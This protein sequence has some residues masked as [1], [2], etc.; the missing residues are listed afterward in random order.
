MHLLTLLLLLVGFQGA[1]AA[2][3]GP[4]AQTE[5]VELTLLAERPEFAPDRPLWLAFRFELAPGWHVYWRNPG[6]SGE[7]PRVSWTLPDGWKVGELHWPVPERIPVGPLVNY[8]YKGAVMLLA[9]AHP[10]DGVTG[11]A[12]LQADVD[13]LVCRESCIPQK[14]RLILRL[15]A[16]ST[17]ALTD[18]D[19]RFEATRARWPVALPGQAGYRT[20]GDL[21]QLAVRQTGWTPPPGTSVWFAADR[22]GP[23]A[24][25][26]PQRWHM[27]DGDL[28]V[29]LPA[30][31]APPTADDRLGGVLVVSEQHRGQTLTRGF[32]VDAG[33]TAGPP[34]PAADLPASTH[35]VLVL[36]LAFAGGLL[37]N[38]MPCVLPVLSIKAMSLLTHGGGHAARHGLAY[39]GGVL[40]CFTALAG[41]LLMLRAGGSALGWGFQLQEPLIVVALMYLML[42][43]AL[44]LSGVFALGAGLTGIGQGLTERRGTGGSFATGILA[45]IVASPCTA[46]F[47]GSALGYALTRPAGEALLVFV[48]LAVGFALP[49]L[50]LSLR[51]GWRRLLPAPGPWMERLRQLLAFPLYAT[52]AWLLWVLSQQVGPAPLAAA[53]AG[54]LSLALGLWWIGQDW[55][56]PLQRRLPALAMIVAAV[57][58]AA[59]ASA[60]TTAHKA[61]DGD[62]WSPQRVASLRAAGRAVLVNFTA[63]WCITCKVNERVALST[64]DV[65]DAL[66][67]AD[68]AYLKADWTRHDP[69]ITTALQRHGRSGVPLYLLY[70]AVAG[71]PDILPQLLTEGLVLDALAR[72]RGVNP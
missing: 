16:G 21:I 72:I 50:L 52:A 7:A 61:P 69:L 49:L 62:A 38:L 71:E 9:E 65:R 4:S 26:Q 27:H 55:R 46:P 40:L 58:L 6:D 35:L 23:V 42:A 48:A 14:A 41:L 60:P 64:P 47:M 45:V 13:W 34:R 33:F 36:A 3:A 17:A 56:Q 39:T 15:A 24:A 12:T 51:P 43:L 63:A 53:L 25:S 18:R 30:G 10:P 67:D 32:V 11:E 31:D 29:D 37:L 1:L 22:W 57:V 19:P 44:N 2:D 54:A 28:L 20:A 8:G 59:S 66:A 5:Q 68:V 70:P